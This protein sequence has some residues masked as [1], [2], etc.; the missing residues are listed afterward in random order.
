MRRTS[1][2]NDSGAPVRASRT[3]TPTGEVSTRPSRSARARCS[4]W[5]VRAL[6]I[7]VAAWAANSFRTSS[8]SSVNSSPPSLSLRKKSPTCAP[9]WRSGVPCRVRLRRCAATADPRGREDPAVRTARAQPGHHRGDQ[10]GPPG[11]FD[12]VQDLFRTICMRT[13]ER[14]GRFK[15]DYKRESKGRHRTSLDA[16][17]APLVKALATDQPL[18]P[19]CHDHALSGEWADQ[20]TACRTRSPA[21]TTRCCR[22]SRC[23]S[24]S[25]KTP[26]RARPSWRGC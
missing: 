26:A 21:S 20:I 3:A 15:R 25:P 19:R 7:A 4:P 5:W 9:R 2:L 23:A 14:T 22:A 17:L 12:N 18:A 13:I 8:S 1:R 10:G 11:R 16:S 24:C 6:A